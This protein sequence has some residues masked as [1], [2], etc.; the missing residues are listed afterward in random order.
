MKS[1]EHACRVVRECRMHLFRWYCNE[2]TYLR[3]FSI[4]SFLSVWFVCV[5]SLRG[6]IVNSGG[7]GLSTVFLM[8]YR[9]IIFAFL[10]LFRSSLALVSACFVGTHFRYFFSLCLCV[11]HVLCAFVLHSCYLC[12]AY[13][14]FVNWIRIPIYFE[15]KKNATD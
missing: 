13:K 6:F 3:R 7:F 9:K 14:K 2:R 15:K 11:V 4:I 10:M 8:F 12:V 5:V 1:I